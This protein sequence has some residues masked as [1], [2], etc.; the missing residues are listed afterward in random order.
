[1]IT[2]SIPLRFAPG[3]ATGIQTQIFELPALRHARSGEP[4]RLVV[5][6]S[7]QVVLD[8]VCASIARM[9]IIWTGR[10]ITTIREGGVALLRLDNCA[11]RL[12][13]ADLDDMAA[14][15]AVLH[16]PRYV[17]GFVIEWR[18]PELMEAA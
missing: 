15:L 16:G 2:Y 6:L 5:E 11:R 12:G 3:I 7:G 17:E 4:I 13:Y 18:A 10:R 9:E 1:M 8:A 14:S